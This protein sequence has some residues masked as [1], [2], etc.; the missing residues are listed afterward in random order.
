MSAPRKIYG[1]EKDGVVYLSPFASSFEKRPASQY[2]SR[3][4]AEAQVASRNSPG[5]VNC[6]L[7]WEN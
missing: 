1:W 5:H 6:V 4:E 3:P 2:T 7:V